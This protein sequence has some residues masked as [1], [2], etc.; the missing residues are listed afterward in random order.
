VY[1]DYFLRDSSVDF[2]LSGEAETNLLSFIGYITG[3]SRDPG[4][5]PG[6]GYKNKGQR[7]FNKGAPPTSSST[8]QPVL[9]LTG[10]TKGGV[11]YTASV[12]RGCNIACRFCANHHV[13]GSFF[14]CA[15]PERFTAQVDAPP[16]A[17]EGKTVILN[18]KPGN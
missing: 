16:D 18:K 17:A 3:K 8:L 13:H 15:E 4:L 10:E 12:S 2:T 14:R 5:V 9:T 1:P 6:L 7:L 11:Y